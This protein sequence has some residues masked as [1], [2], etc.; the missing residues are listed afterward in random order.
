M[1]C[2]IVLYSVTLTVT[3][4]LALLILSQ[5]K[6]EVRATLSVQW[7]D[8]DDKMQKKKSTL[9]KCLQT[10][11]HRFDVECDVL[12]V[13]EEGKAEITIKPAAGAVLLNLIPLVLHSIFLFFILSF[14]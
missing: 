7:S 1:L 13:S 2:Y 14:S 12:K 4:A 3:C 10:L 8:D 11:V 6:D 5:N 9:Q